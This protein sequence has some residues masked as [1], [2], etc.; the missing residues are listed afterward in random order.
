M[1]VVICGFAIVDA[2]LEKDRLEVV[3]GQALT[4]LNQQTH[5]GLRNPAHAAESSMFVAVRGGGQDNGDPVAGPK[6]SHGSRWSAS[7]PRDERAGYT[8]T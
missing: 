2:R 1:L 6:R 3:C 8:I 7:L 4:G 5:S